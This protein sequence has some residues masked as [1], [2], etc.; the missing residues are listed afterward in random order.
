MRRFLLAAAIAT[1]PSAAL[2]AG[3]IP[4]GLVADLK[5]QLEQPVTL[6][7]LRAQNA[8]HADLTQAEIDALDKQWRAEHEQSDQPLMA[9]LMGNPMTTY[10]TKLT[11]RSGGLLS[12][13]FVM[14]NKGLNVGQ[15]SITSDYWQGD[16]A[17][18]QKTVSVGGDAVFVDE[19]EVNET[20]GNRFRQLSITLTDPATGEV[21]GAAAIDVNIDEL[22]RRK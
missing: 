15:S 13:I 7:M 6:I 5:A 9:R 21:L 11:A 17:K 8:K 20:H 14:D 3:E 12:E 4:D 19:I 10:V 2:A 1:V 18:Y 22:E 16:E